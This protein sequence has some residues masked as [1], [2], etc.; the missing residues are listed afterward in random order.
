[1]DAPHRYSLRSRRSSSR[2]LRG[3][4]ILI[5]IFVDLATFF[6]IVLPGVLK[7]SWRLSKSHHISGG[8]HR[9]ADKFAA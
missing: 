4:C 2:L 5:R 7:S 6:A 8:E 9:V 1:P 3:K